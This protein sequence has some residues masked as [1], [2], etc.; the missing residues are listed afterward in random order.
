MHTEPVTMQTA[1]IGK[2]QRVS[3]REV[4]KHEAYDFGSWP[5]E[6]LDA[7]N[8]V[9]DL[10]LQNGERE[11]AAGDFCVALVVE[12]DAGHTVVVENQL[13]K[14]GHDRLGKPVTYLTAFEAKTAIWIVSAPRPEHAITRRG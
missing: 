12:D 8:D 5:E 11:K 3:L 13:G 9:L 1:S 4:W 2:I 7:L 14:S 6:N 10:D